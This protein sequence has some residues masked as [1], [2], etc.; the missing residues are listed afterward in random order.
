MRQTMLDIEI[1]SN[2]E[3]KEVNMN[4]DWGRKITS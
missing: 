2:K 4:G 1:K 3:L